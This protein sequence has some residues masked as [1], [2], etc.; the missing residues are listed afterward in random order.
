MKWWGFLILGMFFISTIC[1]VVSGFSLFFNVDVLPFF[2]A[3]G[4]LVIVLVFLIRILP[5]LF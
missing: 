3:S 2:N 4:F 5:D 1:W